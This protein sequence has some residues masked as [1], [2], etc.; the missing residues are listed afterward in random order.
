MAPVRAADKREDQRAA[1]YSPG[2]PAEGLR[3]AP[4]TVDQYH[5]MIQTDILPEGAPIELIEGLLVSRDRSARGEDPMTVGTRHVLMVSRLARLEREL[6]GRGCFLRL[7]APVS[8]PPDSEPEPDGAVVR[9]SP[10]AY[11]DRHPGPHDVLC[12]FEV[13]DH[14]LLTDR[15]TKQRIYARAGIAQYVIV[16]IRE[17]QIELHAKPQR[18]EGRYE[19]VKIYKV[20][21]KVRLSLE[22]KESIE[23]P[24]DLLLS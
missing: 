6:E 21:Q 14:S 11:A 12:V 9:G 3:L 15:T 1:V 8:I 17:R 16:N 4:V 19:S 20:G 18:K 2:P 24:A 13:A 5:R 22:G 10:D 23:L 7:Q